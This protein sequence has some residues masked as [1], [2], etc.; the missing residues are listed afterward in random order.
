M[1]KNVKLKSI[2]FSLFQRTSRFCGMR[3]LARLYVD[4]CHRR[5]GENLPPQGNEAIGH[6][7]VPKH[8]SHF[9][10]EAKCETFVVKM[11][12]ICIIIKNHFHINGFALRLALKERFFGT[13]KW[14]IIPFSSKHSAS[15]GGVWNNY[16]IY[17]RAVIAG[18]SN[19]F[20]GSF[21]LFLLWSSQVLK[22]LFSE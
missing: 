22:V 17:F 20:S 7:R 14:P 16:S 10:N 15:L 18:Q 1:R 8:L 2:F 6:F 9:Q 12:F 19:G 4:V 3:F 11:S 5:L 13:R 21:F